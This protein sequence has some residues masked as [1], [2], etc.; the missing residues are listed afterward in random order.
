MNDEHTKQLSQKN[1]NKLNGIL[2]ATM[3]GLLSDMNGTL[4]V[5]IDRT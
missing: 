2:L 1:S 4:Y 5:S 3:L